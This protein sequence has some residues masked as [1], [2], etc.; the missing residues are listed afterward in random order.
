MFQFDVLGPLRVSRDGVPVP[1]GAAM[2]RRLLATLLCA[3]GRPVA[4]PALI[5]SLWGDDPPP[6]AHKTLQVYVLR[7]R[8]AMGERDRI[9]HGAGGYAV[10]VRPSELD[11]L[12]FRDLAAAGRA[13]RRDADP[14]TAAAL[15]RRAL[16]LWRG[17][18]YAG[19]EDVALVADEARRLEEERLLA[20]EE[21]AIV[22][23]ARGRDAELVTD[24]T[25][26]AG[27]HPYRERLHACLMLALCRAG[28]QVEALEVY[29][30]A[31]TVLGEELGVE[32]GR[33]L[34]R[35]HEAILRGDAPGSVVDELLGPWTDDGDGHGTHLD[36]GNGDAE[37]RTSEG[38]TGPAAIAPCH[39][40]PD[41]ADFTGRA[42][43]AESLRRWLADAG[44][45][46]TMTVAALYGGAG[47]GKTALALHVAHRLRETFPDG[48]LY[49]DLR[50]TREP[51][52]DPAEATARLL[53]A[54]GVDAR[55]LPDGAEER[56]RLLRAVLADRRVLLVLDDAAGEEQVRPLLPGGAGC[57]VLITGRRRPAG[58][59]AH[60]VHV[61]A[62]DPASAT[63]LLGRIAGPERVAAG[64]SVAAEIV[65]L[66]DHLPLAVRIAG[67]KLALREHWRLDDLADRL[68]DERRRLDELAV[69]DLSVRTG[70]AAGYDSLDRPARRALR[71]L[72][73]LDVPTFAAWTLAAALDVTVREAETYA[74]LL[75][76][77]QWLRCEGGDGAGGFR[78][79]LPGLVR[80]YARERAELEE[81]PG[82]R[83]KAVTRALG[84]LLAMAD[85]AGRGLPEQVASD[86]R[87]TAPRWYADPVTTRRLVGDPLAWFDGEREALAEGVAQACRLGLDELAWELSARAAGYYAVR[88]HYRDW[89]STHEA[90]LK[91][92]AAGGNQ[93]GEA[94]MTR[95]LG[96]LRMAG[97]EPRRDVAADKA[98]EALAVFR[99]AG[100]RHGEVDLLCLRA[101]AL[102][103]AGDPEQARAVADEAM[104]T[105]EEI[106]Y[107]LAQ[108]RLWYVQAVTWREQ[109]R[110][111]DAAACAEGALRLAVRGGG[112]LTRALTL[113]ELA[114]A[115]RDHS[116]SRRVSHLLWE[117]LQVCRPRG[118]R[119]AEA[120]LLLALGDL[121]LRFGRRNAARLVEPALAV[122]GEFRVPSGQAAGLRVLGESHRLDARP[123]QAVRTLTDAVG[124]A[125]DL[126]DLHEQALALGALGRAQRDRGD[127]VAAARSWTA[128]HGLFQRLGDTGGAA[129]I[130]ASLAEEASRTAG[131][132]GWGG[133]PG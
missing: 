9:V 90:A 121:R 47:I 30:R 31:R 117:G 63:A 20:H 113:W 55:E 4:V 94:V 130:A 92:C 88:G 58:L 84:G 127:P 119:L 43:T 75:V 133:V 104:V 111:A 67:A 62:L 2:L 132:P 103:R 34:R 27:L 24:L 109:G 110:H 64:P 61:D 128:A 114:A 105:A 102:C 41:V 97:V 10:T 65:R 46:P 118:E 124:V 1:L 60:C 98:E 22:D 106:G 131:L 126:G 70:L 48:R 79:R 17:P 116:A 40:P 73:L 89:S 25:E 5:E 12:R 3:A 18:A 38:R 53:V 82:E 7:L 68:R 14:A 96:Y 87:G 77:A 81:A 66:C 26:M 19:V 115:C 71:L 56:E 42:E 72:G 80:L 83:D 69:G 95:D 93:W 120:Y 23:L 33:T 16:D 37:E 74:D 129:E 39:L 29:R 15:F 76:D 50:G 45:S 101:L 32:P 107:D 44:P 49:L 11:A 112:V 108:A 86:I 13:A 123:E 122:F 59:S 21:L 28:R 51:P 36:I 52:V 54:L 8:R 99:T 125:R 91:A 6:S 35:V 85:A 78:Y 100:E 57:A